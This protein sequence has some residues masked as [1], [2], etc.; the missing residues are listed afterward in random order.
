MMEELASRVFATRDAAHKEHW[1]TSSY[2]QHVA[3]GE[4]YGELPGAIDA[5]VEAY[6]GHV[7]KVDSVPQAPAA[8]AAGEDLLQH[9]RDE[10]D[11]LEESREELAAGS[12]AIENLIDSLTNLYQNCIYKLGELS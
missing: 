10:A 6:M 7:G 9:L 2:A 3:L 12:R 11:W 5:I 1:R 4:F 8:P